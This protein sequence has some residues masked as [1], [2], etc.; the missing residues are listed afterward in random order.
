MGQRN[1]Q[2]GSRRVC[3]SVHRRVSRMGARSRLGRVVGV[4]R[5][6]KVAPTSLP[7]P[8]RQSIVQSCKQ[9]SKWSNNMELALAS[10][11]H[12]GVQAMP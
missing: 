6:G 7:I 1:F 10:Y 2:E 5:D 8:D 3:A 11:V 4:H 12:C 9:R